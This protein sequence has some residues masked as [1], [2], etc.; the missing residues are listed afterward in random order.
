MDKS[1]KYLPSLFSR[2][3][4]IM[5]EPE[6][7]PVI[8]QTTL[9]DTPVQTQATLVKKHVVLFG[10]SPS[11]K[12]SVLDAI[13]KPTEDFRK[14]EGKNYIK[15]WSED[16][17]FLNKVLELNYKIINGE[18]IGV[19]RQNFGPIDDSKI[20]EKKKGIFTIIYEYLFG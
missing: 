7:E 5:N 11:N 14:E 13:P 6:K 15:I 1:G 18:I 17:T 10:F 3:Q 4:E 2:E 8:P 16:I 9:Y 19:Y 20:Y 12:K